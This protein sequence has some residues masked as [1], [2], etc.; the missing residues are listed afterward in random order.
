MTMEKLLRKFAGRNSS[1]RLWVFVSVLVVAFGPS[2]NA[3]E[4]KKAHI[5]QVIQDVKLLGSN[6]APRAAAVNDNVDEGT[7]V[8][9]GSD[10]RTELTFSDL[11]IT[12]LGENTIFSYKAGSRELDLSGGAVLVEVPPKGAA[13][14][15]NTAAVTAAITGGTALF[16]KGPPSKF[17][18]LEGTGSF[19]RAGHPEEAETVQGGEMVMMTKDGKITRPTK[20]NAAL[21]YKTAKLITSFPTLPNEDLILAVIE[22]QETPTSV[23]PPDPP[24]KDPS[25]ETDLAIVSNPTPPASTSLK[26]GPLSVITTPDP[27]V[28][29][30]GTQIGTDPT[31]TTSGKTDLGKIYRGT[32]EDGFPSDYLFGSTTSFDTI[33]FAG[34]VNGVPVAVFKFSD[35]QLTGDPTISIPSGATT[36]LGLVSV[37]A[38]TSGMPG[39]TLTFAG[40]NRL[41]IAT[42]NGS[43]TLGP[44]I[45]F[46]GID[47]L[48]FYARGSGSNLTLASPIS[49]GSVVHLNAEGTVQIN[50]NI[51]ASSDF[52]SISGSDFLTGSGTVTALNLDIESLSNI[53]FDSSLFPDVAGGSIN[54]NAA[55]TLDITVTGGTYGRDSLVA[56]GQTINLTSAGVVTLDFANATVSFTAGTGGFNAPNVDLTGSGAGLDFIS[57]GSITA[58]SITTSGF[59]DGT[60]A[61][62]GGSLTLTGDL[63][64]GAVSALTNISVGGNATAQSLN[65]GGTITVGG[66]MR[67][68]GA[69]TAGG[70][71]TAD[72]VDI[73]TGGIT[74][75]GNLI[76]GSGG[77]HPFVISPGGAALQA[78]ATVA[79]IT[80]PNGIDFSGNQF[81][82]IDGLSSGG[83]LTI[84]ANTITFDPAS[85]IASA[86]FDGADSGA[87]G[88]GSP[89]DGGDGGVFIVNTT[90]DITANNGADI[91]ATTGVN[92]A[93]GVFSGA[94]GSVT[95]HS[96]GGVVT[97]DDTIQVS[98]DDA[99][100]QRQSN[101][102]GTILLQSNLTTG[103]GI[104]VG[105]N[106]QLLSLLNVGAAGPG[107]SITLSTMGANI[108]V[109]PGAVIQAD[110]GTISMDQT[111]PPN[112]IPIISIEGA[113]LSSR[114]L[115]I[116]GA[117]DL[118]IGL[119]FP[120]TI[121]ADSVSLSVAHDLHLGA[122]TL[123][124][125]AS[126]LSGSAN[127]AGGAISHATDGG[128]LNINANS[129]T[130]GAGLFA[131]VTLNGA[132]A[133]STFGSGDGGTFD[134][135]T[136]GDITAN[137]GADITATTGLNSAAGVFGGTGGS[138]TLQSSTGTVAVNDTIQVSSDDAPAQRQSASGGDINITSGKTTGV[139]INVSNSAQLL[140]LLNAAAPGPGGKI[141]IMATAPTSNS[142]VNVSG[143]VR[144]DRGT[145]DIEHA[146]DNG[147]INISNA[148]I[149]ADIVKIGAFGTNG[150]LN[151][152]GGILSA[153][154]TL[155][156]Y[157]PG[158]SGT[159]N[160]IAD[161]TLSGASTKIIAADTVKIFDAI[162]VTIGGVNPAS[163]FTNHAHYTGF[164]GDNTTTGTF[165]GA[166]ATTS[167]LAGAPHY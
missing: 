63:L 50:A 140:A 131:S 111:D 15:I 14:R 69:I 21:V 114:A 110:R 157:A 166:G 27:Y 68:F 70:D 155:K 17:L 19:Y 148:D 158:S 74:T 89:P 8:R 117:G 16:S 99:P 56:Q 90:G 22:E 93:A 129:L 164:G 51:T 57:A 127:I 25:D 124:G 102:G 41:F 42:Q 43:I 104:N 153:D 145:I 107:G 64:S 38:I 119:N 71:I 7:A 72:T 13:I 167:A 26:F 132:D 32:S 138:V 151:V 81:Q 35:L 29:S 97:V 4:L 103:P 152:G 6:A 146:G 54:L 137:N 98:S 49:G 24:P 160:F 91:T 23:G 147:Q 37:G 45:A 85:G 31:I 76:A 109:S 142:S 143:T 125:L 86:N 165:A 100:N 77:I 108:T 58:H 10:S 123:S 94:G 112:Q 135:N 128:V 96:S 44:E 75:P 83:R 150:T 95:L 136:T 122:I 3:E 12:R 39:G 78:T 33:V 115:L 40:I 121:H 139:A 60:I 61:A 34:P 113:T 1:A 79:T 52:R 73:S 5:S 134:V 88:S 156:L 101:S 84:N 11:T 126:D 28:I 163:V 9:T 2:G 162:K 130:I 67:A 105:A 141:T 118:D 55:G 47:H 46:S 82:G 53:T 20:F 149:R 144:A 161:V 18:V 30:S 36:F 62:N 80:S 48:D 65:A 87:F 106:A 116:S 59:A 92:S 66:E 154:T 120:V 133:S 159:I